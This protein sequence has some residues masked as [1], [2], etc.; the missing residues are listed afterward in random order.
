MKRERSAPVAGP[1]ARSES[2]KPPARSS[3]GVTPCRRTPCH[4]RHE[5][6]DGMSDCWHAVDIVSGTRIARIICSSYAR[7]AF[8]NVSPCGEHRGRAWNPALHFALQHA[9]KADE[10]RE[11]RAVAR[12]TAVASSTS[13]SVSTIAAGTVPTGVAKTSESA[14]MPA[15]PDPPEVRRTSG[16]RE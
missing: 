13:R 6:V 16:S 7:R 8:W 10:R 2:A 4:R 5:W 12:T 9:E 11:K 14:R 15:F 1:P 3:S